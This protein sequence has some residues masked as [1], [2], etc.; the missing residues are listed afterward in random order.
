MKKDEVIA[1]L[2]AF[3]ADFEKLGAKLANEINDLPVLEIPPFK[4]PGWSD[5][6]Q[7]VNIHLGLRQAW[8]ISRDSNFKIIRANK[9]TLVIVVNIERSGA[10]RTF[11]HNPLDLEN[12]LEFRSLNQSEA[13][14]CFVI[15][16]QF[17]KLIA[18]RMVRELKKMQEKAEED[19]ERYKLLIEAVERS[20]EG[21]VPFLVA[22]K[23]GS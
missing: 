19:K 9:K 3:L 10:I 23:L 5:P 8:M 13:L 1:K 21:L 14:Q 6:G 2:N 18:R 11:C 7:D 15:F 4:M 12:K 17:L 16:S 22:D 20:L